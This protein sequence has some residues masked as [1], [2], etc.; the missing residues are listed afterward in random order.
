MG[1]YMTAED[2]KH[3]KYFQEWEFACPCGKCSGLPKNGMYKSLIDNMNTLRYIYNT[4]ITITSGYRCPSYNKAVGGDANSKHMLGGACDFNFTGQVFGESAKNK[5]IDMCKKLPNYHYSYSN[6][7]NM[8]NAV[9]LD[10]NLVEC[11]S[12]GN[13]AAVKEIEDQKVKI[14]QLEQEIADLKIAI[15]KLDNE[16]EL[17]EDEK[18]KLTTEN[19]MLKAQLDKLNKKMEEVSNEY[20]VLFKL[21]DLY[22]CVKN[23]E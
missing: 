21:F 20:K 22:I 15:E 8:Y 18:E 3:S 6:Q 7:S 4:S 16:K 17:V 5:I 12:W 9:H 14:A 23:E 13:A 19:T 11:A 2:W 10:T 1:K